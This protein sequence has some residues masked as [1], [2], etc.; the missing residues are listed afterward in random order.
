[1]NFPT[2]GFV[3]SSAQ[4]SAIAKL[5]CSRR[6]GSSLLCDNSGLHLQVNRTHKTLPLIDLVDSHYFPGWFWGTIKLVAKNGQ[7]FRITGL[8][9]SAAQ[10]L[11]TT[12]EHNHKAAIQAFAAPLANH[13]THADSEITT[14]TQCRAYLPAQISRYLM[15]ISESLQPLF[16][17]SLKP[18]LLP[19]SVEQKIKRVPVGAAIAQ[20]PEHYRNE[21]GVSFKD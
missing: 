21:C 10:E 3:S 18:G 15:S 8:P 11:A 17:L 16:D 13:L 12:I 4:R 7:K 5:V 2:L 6:N 20:F 19:A 14:F 9:K 1:M